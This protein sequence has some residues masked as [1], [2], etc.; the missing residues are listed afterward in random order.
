[1]QS[2]LD[3]PSSG[4]KATQYFPRSFFSTMIASSSSSET[5]TEQ[6]PESFS[7]PTMIS[8]LRISCKPAAVSKTPDQPTICPVAAA[9]RH[10]VAG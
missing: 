9:L 7:A 10:Y 3:E 8:L 2:M 6:Q 4:S 1:M 5:S